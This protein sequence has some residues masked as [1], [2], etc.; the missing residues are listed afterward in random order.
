MARSTS[1]SEAEAGISC[2]ASSLPGFR[3][4]LKH[5]YADFIVHEVA[6]DGALVQLTSFDLPTESVGVNEEDKAAPSAEADHSQALESFRSLCG[7]ADCNALRGLLEK[8]SGEGGGDVSPVILSPDADKAH[9]SEVHNFFKKTFKFLVTDTVEHSDGVQKCI[10]VRF[11]SE[12]G[13]GRGA[14]GRG[15]GRKRKNMGSSDWRDGRPFDSRGSS[16][17]PDNVGKFLRFHLY[18]ENKDTQEALGVI[19]KMLGL[20]PR[21]FGFA[22]TK[23]KRAVTTQQACIPQVYNSRVTVF[24]V[25]ASKLLALNKRLFGIKVGNFCYVKEGLV[26][27]QLTGNRFTITLRGVTAESE[28]MIKIAVDGLGKNGFINYYGLQE[29]V[30]SLASFCLNITKSVQRDDI[31]EVR[32]RYK[33]HGDIDMALRNFPRHLVAERAILQC[34]KKCPGNHLQALKGIPRT[35]RMMYV[36]SYQSYLWNHAAS[37]RVEKYGIS[38]VVEGDLVYNKECPSE[39][40]TSVDILETDDDHTNS[41]EI[42]LCSEAQPEE[43][44]QSAKIVDS[45]DFTKGIYTF[46]DVVLPLPGWKYLNFAFMTQD[47]ISLT[48]NAHGVKEFSITSMKGGYRRVFQRPIG[49]EW[50]LITYTDD[51][52]SLAETDLDVLSRTKP[53]EANELISK[54]ESQDKLEKAPDTS[55]PTNGNSSQEK[56]IGSPDI[57]PKKLALKLAFT[58]PTSCYATM[59]IRELLKTSTSVAYQKTLSC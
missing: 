51:T 35:L 39:E 16:N 29:F 50:E 9:R 23:D 44:I 46:D 30:F 56:L 54:Q 38:Q 5:R 1:L 45:G 43:S 7:D 6:R 42:D 15:R 41:I 36:H 27:G 26:L 17:W 22:G 3:G 10:R 34:L 25:Q 55:V 11:G 24:K 31:N 19:G 48:E 58:L 57:R 40:S 59:A 52:S 14:G 53:K 13:V 32:K 47:G 28:D 12:A 33:E 4:V 20:Q 49:F 18:K 8:V 21:S 2:F 37:M